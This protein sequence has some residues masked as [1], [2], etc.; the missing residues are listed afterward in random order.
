MVYNPWSVIKF[1]EDLTI[2]S[3]AMPRLYWTGMSG[4]SIVRKLIDNADDTTREKAEKLV[5][6]DEITFAMRN[7]IFDDDLSKNPIKCS[8]SC[9][10]RAT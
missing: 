10:P 3:N 6:G 9:L 5:Q 2:S 4:N 1:I 7:D 8:M